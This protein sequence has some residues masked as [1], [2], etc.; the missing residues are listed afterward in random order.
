MDQASRRNLGVLSDPGISVLSIDFMCVPLLNAGRLDERSARGPSKH[1]YECE[2]NDHQRAL[3]I[4]G[5]AIR[6]IQRLLMNT[7]AYC[8]QCLV[9]RRRLVGVSVSDEPARHV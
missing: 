6:Q 5:V 9:L 3:Q 7:T 1:E 4:D 8:Y 2:R